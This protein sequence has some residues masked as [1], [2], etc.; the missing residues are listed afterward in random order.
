[1]DIS[2]SF[3][4]YAAQSFHL[5]ILHH[6]LHA[7]KVTATDMLSCGVVGWLEQAWKL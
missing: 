5:D 4:M 1:M 7:A 6:T 2:T 3:E